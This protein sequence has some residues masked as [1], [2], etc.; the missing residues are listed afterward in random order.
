MVQGSRS[1]IVQ[2]FSC[3]LLYL[4]FFYDGWGTASFGGGG[5]DFWEGVGCGDSYGGGMGES[6]YFISGSAIDA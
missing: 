6:C 3:L 5:G 4:Y 2:L 1:W